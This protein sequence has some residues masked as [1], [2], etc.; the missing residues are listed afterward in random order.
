MAL[1]LTAAGADYDSGNKGR[2]GGNGPR[3]LWVLRSHT[4]RVHCTA[5][6]PTRVLP[7]HPRVRYSAEGLTNQERCYD[8]SYGSLQQ[9]KK[10][11]AQVGISKAE[12]R[13]GWRSIPAGPCR[14]Q[15]RVRARTC[16]PTPRRPKFSAAVARSLSRVQLFA[17][18]WTVAH[19]A[20]LSLG[21]PGKS[22]RWGPISFSRRS[23][24]GLNQHLLVAE[25]PGTPC[26]DVLTGGQW[27]G[28][29]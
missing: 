20:P 11:K 22:T 17:T 19:Q 13:E 24:R 26:P 1:L 7:D 27:Q 2:G 18:P 9:K 6:G 8:H 15:G 5:L 16:S 25:P 21:L 3:R 28:C 10:K 29:G 12:R 4:A 14:R 23:S